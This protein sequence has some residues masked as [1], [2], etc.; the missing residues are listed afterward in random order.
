MGNPDDRRSFWGWGLAA[1]EPSQANREA[2][3]GQLGQRYGVELT[4]R[5]VP[6]HR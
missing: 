1:D 4:A 6:D 2:L 3:A 5:P